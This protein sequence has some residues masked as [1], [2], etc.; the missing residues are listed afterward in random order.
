MCNCISF[1]LLRGVGWDLENH[2]GL[3]NPG[4]PSFS[5]PD[6]PNELVFCKSL[7]IARGVLEKKE[8]G[9]R[10]RVGV[11]ERLIMKIH[12]DW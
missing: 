12:Y 7:K 6:N 1:L 5:C 9:K 11:G 3:Y 8:G 4:L 10:V 2:K